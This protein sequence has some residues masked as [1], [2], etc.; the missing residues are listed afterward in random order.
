M[1]LLGEVA[2]LTKS[3]EYKRQ[4]FII[5]ITQNKFRVTKRKKKLCNT[6]AINCENPR[7]LKMNLKKNEKFNVKFAK[8]YRLKNSSTPFMQRILDSEMTELKRKM[9]FCGKKNI[10]KKGQSF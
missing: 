1:E 6:F 10:E 5:Y 2:E 7:I 3:I 9:T 8:P 4:I